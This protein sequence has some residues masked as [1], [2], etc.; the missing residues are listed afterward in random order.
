MDI[1]LLVAEGAEGLTE[2]QKAV[3][4]DR[5]AVASLRRTGAPAS[6]PE[7][8]VSALSLR[9]LIVGIVCV[10]L[11]CLVVCYAELVIAKIQIG[12][13]QLPPVVVGMLVLLLGVQAILT[14]W[15]ARLRLRAH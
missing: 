8:R 12:F 1:L 15:S 4:R 6:P 2:P 14:R 7:P 11:T 10:A 3:D 13:L 5:L 9:A